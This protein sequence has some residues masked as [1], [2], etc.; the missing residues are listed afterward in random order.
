MAKGKKFKEA[1]QATVTAINAIED[2]IKSEKT[3][4]WAK[5][6][7]KV[8]TMRKDLAIMKTGFSAWQ[9]S[10]LSSGKNN[11]TKQFAPAKT[12]M[13]LTSLIENLPKLEKLKLMADQIETIH[14]QMIG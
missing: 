11:V 5:T 6:N 12:I 9:L 10:F 4:E 13:E 14:E 8:D 1:Y 3:W 7:A 2:C